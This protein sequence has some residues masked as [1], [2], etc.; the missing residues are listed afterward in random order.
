[1]GCR[2]H[3]WSYDT[4]GKL[5]KAPEFNG[6]PGFDKDFNGLWEV[7]TEAVN[8]FVFVNFQAQGHASEINIPK[9]SGG[10]KLGQ[11]MM[12]ACTE[13]KIAGNFNWKLAGE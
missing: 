6:V 9:T 8:G 13:W 4:T 5:I 2:Y 11:M 1:L 3:G 10:T 7:K 12:S